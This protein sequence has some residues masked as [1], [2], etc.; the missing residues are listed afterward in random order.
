MGDIVLVGR[1]RD[2]VSVGLKRVLLLENIL[3]GLELRRVVGLML[4]V[5][6]AESLRLD[7]L[8]LLLVEVI[9]AGNEIW[10]MT[11]EYFN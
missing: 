1:Y 7:V 4:I 8:V 3:L 5:V 11:R 6:G 2:Y 10:L 9:V